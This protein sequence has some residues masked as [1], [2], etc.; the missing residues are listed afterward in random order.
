MNAAFSE[1]VTPANVIPLARAAGADATP[2]RRAFADIRMPE[3]SAKPRQTGLTMVLDKNLGLAA[4][5]DMLGSAHHVIDLVKLGWGTSAIQ[6]AEFVRRKCARL[7]AHQVLVCPGGTL[8]ELAWLQGRFDS[9]LTEARSLGFTCIEVSDGTVPMPHDKKLG[10]IRQAIAAGFCVT[11]EVGSK[12]SAEDKR[13]SLDQRVQQIRSELAAGAWKV[14]IEARES[15]TQGIFDSG[16]AT[17]IDLL[18]QLIDRIDADHLIFEAPLRSQ[19][20]DLVLTLGNRVNLGNVAPADAVPLET[21][22]LGLRSDTLRHYHMAYPSIRIGL[23]A[24]G[25]LSA[26]RRG[27]VVVV[28]DAL[29]ASSTIVAALAHGMRSVRPVSSVEECTGDVTAGERGGRK[30][31]QLQYDNSPL[32][33]CDAAMKGREL[34]LTSSNGTECLNAAASHPGAVTLVGCLLNAAAVARSALQ[35]AQ[36]RNSNISIVCA[37]RNHQMASEDL[38]AASEIAMAMPGAP[39]LGDIKPLTCTDYYRD[40]LASD[41][42]RNLSSLGKTDDV[43]FCAAKDRFPITPVYRDGIIQL[44]A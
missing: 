14:I 12:L 18:Q 41:S 3:R 42:G 1:L 17:Q 23:G 21:L 34:V 31:E 27:D 9:F 7:A 8:A 25:A 36:Q 22:R 11:S 33:F 38:I 29:R 5:E 30:I 2:S 37:G 43:I 15:G 28:V 39:V 16:G 26:S 20:T 6:D 35:M 4:L 13:I 44:E 19:Q 32:A 24:A 40:F 10:L